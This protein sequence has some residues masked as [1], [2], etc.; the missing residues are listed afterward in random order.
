M[1]GGPTSLVPIVMDI[2]GGGRTAWIL[3]AIYDN[4]HFSMKGSL[5]VNLQEMAPGIDKPWLKE[6]LDKALSHLE[7]SLMFPHAS[8]THLNPLKSDHSP[9]LVNLVEA[10]GP[11]RYKRTFR[12]LVARLTHPS[13]DVLLCNSWN[14]YLPW[15]DTISHLQDDFKKWNREVS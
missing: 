5:W 12:M 13:F 15:S 2:N 14:A 4:P 9:L 11:N 6:R 1:S 3:S 8:V 10:A 7:W